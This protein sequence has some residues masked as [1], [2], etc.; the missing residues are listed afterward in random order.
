M[1]K[2][3][4]RGFRGDV[5]NAFLTIGKNNPLADKYAARGYTFCESR[6]Q[7]F[8]I[9]DNADG[10]GVFAD[11]LAVGDFKDINGFGVL[12]VR[13]GLRGEVLEFDAVVPRVEEQGGVTTI[14]DQH[15]AIRLGGL[16]VKN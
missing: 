10:S 7:W 11:E 4:N 8:D 14:I 3:S 13:S 5:L 2:K 15:R 12:Q 16:R 9:A 6:H 1:S